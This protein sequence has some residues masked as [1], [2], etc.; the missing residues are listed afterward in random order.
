MKTQSILWHDDLT[1]AIG[2]TRIALGERKQ[3]AAEMFPTMAPASAYAKLAAIE[4]GAEQC[5]GE[6]LLWLMRR[7][8]EIGC[9]A[10]A[11]YLCSNAGYETPRPRTPEEQRDEAVEALKAATLA[12]QRAIA[13][14]EQIEQNKNRPALRGVGR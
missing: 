13:V 1:D 11:E 2:T 7:G 4:K 3:V 12:Q 14:L 6:S 9:H 10:I 8:R 5:S